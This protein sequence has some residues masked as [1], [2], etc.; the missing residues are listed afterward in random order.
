MRG[1]K[2]L[3]SIAVPANAYRNISLTSMAIYTRGDGIG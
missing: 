1:R 3:P 2:L